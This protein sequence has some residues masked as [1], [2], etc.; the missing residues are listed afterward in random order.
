[1]AV[2]VGAGAVVAHRG[3]RICMPGGDLYVTQ[4]Y[5]C[6]KHCRNK[7]CLSMCGCMRG[8]LTP[9]VSAR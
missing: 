1:M 9:A 7:V 8:I 4:I 6:I 5:A 3:A 2:K